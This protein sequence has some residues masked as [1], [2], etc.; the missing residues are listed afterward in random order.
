LKATWKRC[1]H[2]SKIGIHG[3]PT[4]LQGELLTDRN[5]IP[6]L[7]KLCQSV[8]KWRLCI[9]FGDFDWTHPSGAFVML[10]DAVHATL[11]YL[12]SGYESLSILSLTRNH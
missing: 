5:S 8:Q 9:R 6:K 4:F 10:G 3:Q 7:L 1:V 12:A 11:P 2:C